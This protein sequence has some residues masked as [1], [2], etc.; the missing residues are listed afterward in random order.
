MSARCP[1]WARSVA[2]G[3]RTRTA[4]GARRGSHARASQ[5]SRGCNRTAARPARPRRPQR[6][7]SAAPR[8]G[9]GSAPSVAR[10]APRRTE[11]PS[12]R[13]I[14]RT[15]CPESC[16][17]SRTAPP[18]SPETRARPRFCVE[19]PDLRAVWLPDSTQKRPLVP[20]YSPAKAFTTPTKAPEPAALNQNRRQELDDPTPRKS[21]LMR[22]HRRADSVRRHKSR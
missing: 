10:T 6:S 18:R 1:S 4:P 22:R 3:A 7:S 20:A 8:T 16:R 2:P 15:T 21:R 5:P 13:L 19:S 12:T 11:T 17:P 9:A 14:Y